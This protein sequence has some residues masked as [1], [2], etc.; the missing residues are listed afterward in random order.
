MIICTGDLL[1]LTDQPRI[2]PVGIKRTS[3]PQPD[4]A[5]WH[6]V[7]EAWLKCSLEALLLLFIACVL[8]PHLIKLT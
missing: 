1:C 6:Q 2:M 3:V 4:F 5:N 7:E 8:L